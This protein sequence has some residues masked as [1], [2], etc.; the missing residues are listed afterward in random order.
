MNGVIFFKPSASCIPPASLTSSHNVA[1]G[2]LSQTPYVSGA[3]VTGIRS[4]MSAPRELGVVVR[5]MQ[6]SMIF[7]S[8]SFFH[9]LLFDGLFY[10][11]HVGA[12]AGSLIK[13]H[14]LVDSD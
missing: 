4:R 2:A 7:P 8:T 11:C 14:V 6:L 13:G 3:T 10:L 5:I 12:R 1:D 9:M